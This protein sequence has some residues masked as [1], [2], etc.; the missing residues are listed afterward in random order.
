MLYDDVIKWKH[1][2]RNWP[3]VREIHRSPV[4]FPHKGQWR[5]ALMFS[6]MYAWINDWVNNREAGDLRLQHGHYDVIVMNRDKLSADIM[7]CTYH[8]HPFIKQI[9]LTFQY[10]QSIRLNPCKILINSGLVTPYGDRYLGKH[11][12]V[13][14]QTTQSHYPNQFWPI[15]SSNVMWLSPKC[16]RTGNDHNNNNFSTLENYASKL[17]SLHQGDD[18]S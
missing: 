17:R 5:G 11:W 6:L 15:I 18:K 13:A 9:S 10:G 4:N 14:W 12:L 1:F 3:F 7:I 2:P 8:T 16:N